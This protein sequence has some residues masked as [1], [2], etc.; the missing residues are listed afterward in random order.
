MNK[1]TFLISIFFICSSFSACNQDHPKIDDPTDFMTINNE[2]TLS[3]NFIGNGAQWGG[4]DIIE[5]WTGNDDFTDADWDKMTERMDFMRPPFIRIMTSAG[6]SYMDADQTFKPE[7][8]TAAFHRIM[9]Y[10]T[11]KEI[12]V[13]F[14]EWGHQFLN[15]DRNNINLDAMDLTIDYIDHLVNEEGYSCIKYFNMIN[16][17]NGSWSTTE[18]NYNIW[19]AV[20]TEFLKRFEAKGLNKQVKYTGPD[21]AVF[22]DASS[23][24]WIS[25]S[26]DDFGDDIELF[27]LHSYPT[28]SFVNGDEYLTSLQAFKDAIPAGKQIVIG[29]IGLKYYNEDVD[30]QTENEKRIEADPYAS[31]DSNMM[32]YDGFYGV[33]VSDAMVQSM[34]AGF[35]GALVW[36]VDDAMYNKTGSSHG[37]D[38][39]KLKRWGFWNILG[40][41]AFESSEDEEIRPFFYPISLLCRYFP[42]G[43]DI[44]EVDLPNRK[45]LRAVAARMGSKYTI[46]IV[47]SGHVAYKNI[48]LK[49][50]TDLT[51]NAVSVYEYSSLS[52]GGFIG[53]MNEHGFPLPQEENLSIDFDGSFSLDIPGQSVIVITNME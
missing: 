31:D 27:D 42:K 5:S 51:I 28:K 30:I 8:A 10:C 21:I 43:S 35:S 45:G 20:T 49:S 17:P 44:I 46:A 19:K 1:I 40:E 18:G 12:T 7:R 34:M 29:E 9:K 41:E 16:E 37:T 4:Y 52:D 14:G 26:Y 53:T 47:N 22:S 39:K 2:A 23:T 24:N 32:I 48:G 36:D 13:M 50:D 15:G 3:V 11:E 6:W 33:D 25:N 38:Y